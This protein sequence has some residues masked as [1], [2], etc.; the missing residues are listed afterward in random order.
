MLW[1][2]VERLWVFVEIET[3][4]APRPRHILGVGRVG[5]AQ[6]VEVDVALALVELVVADLVFLVH[7]AVLYHQ[8]GSGLP[9]PLAQGE[10][11]VAA[12]EQVQQR[13]VVEALVEI[14]GPVAGVAQA[15]A[16][17]QAAVGV[18]VLFQEWMDSVLHRLDQLPLQH[19]P[20]R[21]L[22]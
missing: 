14:V 21:G 7:V 12:A 4:K 5:H 16:P 8:F 3:S 17:N 20:S 9:L 22:Y 11:M 6:Q 15:V 19:G 18:G 1:V 2:V 13:P 10:Q